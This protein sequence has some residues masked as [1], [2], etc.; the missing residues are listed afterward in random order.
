MTDQLDT[1]LLQSRAEALVEAARKAGADQADAIA[2]RGVSQSVSVRD[3]KVEE[4]ERSEGDDVSL[5]VFVGRKTAS[6]STNTG[7]DPSALAERAVAMARVAPDDPHVRLADEADLV[8]ELPELDL[9]DRTD[10]SS[11]DLTERALAAESA[12]LDVKDVSKSGGASASW[13]LGGLV[14]VTSTGFS[15]AYLGT[16][17]GVA[18]TAVAG[19]GTGME[20]DYDYASAVHLEDLDDAETIGRNAGERAIRRLNPRKIETQSAAVLYDRRAATGLVGHFASAINGGAIARGTS[21]LKDRMGQQ[22]FADDVMITDD[23][24][25]KRGL[26]SKPFDGEGFAA[27]ALT[28]I[29]KGCLTTW[30]LDSATAH[31]LGLKT[32]GRAARGGSA[33]HPGSTNLTLHAGRQSPEEMM[34]AIGTGLLVTDLIGHGVNGVTGDYSRGA[35]GFWIENGEPAYPVSEITIASNLV[36]MF[37]ALTPASDLEYR[38][39]TNAP[40]VLIEGMTI[41]GR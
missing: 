8:R 7:D 6:V 19:E 40:S 24:R 39:G 27:E 22:L 28:L 35:A 37:R 23:P 25:R 36:D 4:S 38:F 20:R 10:V 17:H 30:L 1:Q 11:S 31:E 41:A 13:S 26:A 33:P 15:G 21:F 2:V 16:R 32:N 34:A 5:R 18:M 12:G 9:L 29:D 14:L 3:G